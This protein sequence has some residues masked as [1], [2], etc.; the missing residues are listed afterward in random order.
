M[1]AYLEGEDIERPPFAPPFL[2]A[3]K[4]LIA[5]TPNIL[6]FLGGRL[7]LAPRDAAGKLWTHQLQLT[8]GD[9]AD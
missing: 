5:Q 6:L 8:L 1:R 4:Q 3:G 2:R 9:F 7:G